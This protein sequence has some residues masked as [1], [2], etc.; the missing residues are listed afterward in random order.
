VV[1]QLIWIHILL[2]KSL[3][4]VYFT[5]KIL[6]Q[7]ASSNLDPPPP[8]HIGIRGLA[9]E[10]NFLTPPLKYLQFLDFQISWKKDTARPNIY[11]PPPPR[12]EAWEPG[13]NHFFIW[14]WFMP[15]NGKYPV[16]NFKKSPRNHQ[17]GGNLQDS[18]SH[19]NIQLKSWIEEMF[20][21]K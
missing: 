1:L 7:K 10:A 12:S 9:N 17:R 21:K 18:Y 15:K 4:L 5:S 19:E 6:S 14:F 11:P 13:L 20:L 3:S 16:A 8:S 2:Q